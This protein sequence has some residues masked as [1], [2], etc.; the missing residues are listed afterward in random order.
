MRVLDIIFVIAGAGV[1]FGGYTLFTN[2]AVVE[3][4]RDVAQPNLPL[5]E[6]A[7]VQIA[8]DVASVRQTALLR[9]AA[10]VSVTS[11]GVGRVAEIN[12]E[13]EL[14]GRLSE[15]DVIF[16]LETFRL[17]TDI[18]RAEADVAA[19]AAEVTRLAQDEVRIAE[20]VERN[21]STDSSLDT[22]RANLAAAIA[23]R[24]LAEAGLAAAELS[25]SEATVVAS[26]D[27][28]VAAEALSEGQFLQP[29]TEVGR[30]VSASAA[31]LVVRLNAGQLYQVQNGEGLMGREVT[32]RATDGSGAVKTG[33]IERVALTAETATQT[34]GVLVSV[35]DPFTA[36][37]GILR[38]NTLV[39]VE[40]PLAGTPEQLLSVPVAAIQTGD[41]IWVIRDGTLRPAAAR[42][43]RRTSAFATIDSDDLQEGDRVLLTRLPDAVE[44]LRVR[45]ADDE[46]HEQSA[47]DE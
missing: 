31:E 19:A 39:E 42:I 46:T 6:T 3:E 8:E 4:A 36:D 16:R 24:D 10:E 20:L 7:H 27:S 33:I 21:V 43:E 26:F 30:L 12:P 23:R 22:V 2:P 37:G 38:L 9:P 32:V 41:R 28:V 34:T 29:G 13:F 40:I 18:T 15:G 45:I 1:V 35:A 5:V 17:R 14:G 25:L 47:V 44:G 11:E